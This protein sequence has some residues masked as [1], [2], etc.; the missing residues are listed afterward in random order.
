MCTVNYVQFLL[1]LVYGLKFVEE[2]WSNF[3]PRGFFFF[4]TQVFSSVFHYFFYPSV[5]AHGIRKF[6]V[7]TANEQ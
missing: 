1:V 4:T 7:D 2:K 5:L 6:T 3:F